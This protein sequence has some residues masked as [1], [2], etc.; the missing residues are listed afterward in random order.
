MLHDPQCCGIEGVRECKR[1]TRKDTLVFSFM[2]S[3]ALEVTVIAMKRTVSM[4]TVIAM[5]CTVSA[6]TVI[7]MKRTVSMVT[8]IAMERIARG[9]IFIAMACVV[10]V[11][12]KIHV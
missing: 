5:K 9:A 4:V 2:V 6:V 8:D 7:A 10:L 1:F 11:P 12:E 3:I